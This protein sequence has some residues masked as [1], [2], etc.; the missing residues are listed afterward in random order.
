MS[1]YSS[2]KATIN[3]NVKTNGNQEITGSVM[4]SVLNAMVN[5]LGAGY[6]FMGVATPTNPGTA[7]TPDYKCFYIATTPGTYTNLGGLVVSDGEVALLKWDTSWTKEVTGV[8][9]AAKVNQI[10]KSVSALVDFV[11][12]GE[13]VEII[14]I[15]NY[16][17]YNGS[18]GGGGRWYISGRTSHIIIPANPGERYL[19]KSD[20]VSGLFGILTSDHSEPVANNS[21]ISYVSGQ[22]RRNATTYQDV[23]IPNGAAYLCLVMV[24]GGQND[25]KWG[26]VAKCGA[27][28]KSTQELVSLIN[29]LSQS[30]IDKVEY[31]TATH[32]L[33]IDNQNRVFNLYNGIS[34]KVKG[35]AAVAVQISNVPFGT[36]TRVSGWCCLV[37]NT[38]T[39]SI[40][41]KQYYNTEIT[42]TDVII[43]VFRALLDHESGSPDTFTIT[44]VYYTMLA[45]KLLNEYGVLIDR[46][47]GYSD[48][49]DI[50]GTQK[51]IES[52]PNFESGYIGANGNTG[53]SDSVVRSADYLR[54]SYNKIYC[55]GNLSLLQSI[56]PNFSSINFNVHCYN[57]K[58]QSLGRAMQGYQIVDNGAYYDLL[59]GTAFVRFT[60]ADIAPN[61]NLANY[62]S[63]INSN[64][65]NIFD[66]KDIHE[67]IF[68]TK[69]ELA[70][71]E[72]EM[73]IRTMLDYSGQKISL[74]QK[75]DYEHIFSLRDAGV[76]NQGAAIYGNYLFAFHTGNAEVDVYD[77]TTNTLVQ[78]ISV[79]D[80]P[81]GENHANNADFGVAFA[82]A[83]DL[84]PLLYVTT[85]LNDEIWVYRVSGTIGNLVMTKHQVISLNTSEIGIYPISSFAV[86]KE[87]NKIVFTGYKNANY[88]VSV[89]NPGVVGYFEIPDTSSD[90]QVASAD[91]HFKEVPWV[92]AFQGCFAVAG[93]IYSAFGN[94]H[95]SAG[96]CVYDYAN[97]I[98]LN[99][100]AISVADFGDYFEPEGLC[101][102]NGEMIMTSQHLKVYNFAF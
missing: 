52:I 39:G 69:E 45:Y 21:V 44:S 78:T 33:V 8:A 67:P 96:I 74:R 75:T 5:S 37:Y 88:D 102:Y 55:K 47:I 29:T 77:L 34:V 79:S 62:L 81:Q 20:S 12:G 90:I 9:A 99:K 1:E 57:E 35:G 28:Y 16:Q 6:Q 26:L 56:I 65:N 3:A 18:L 7:Q 24:D 92:Y 97:G 95:V 100:I 13:D 93:K 50:V 25:T 66:L 59:E 14:D 15:S 94:T 53:A 38:T 36:L 4:N 58:K 48:I 98:V 91:V 86:D 60:F 49:L 85:N 23:V 68:A 61:V 32:P 82:D 10:E 84:F 70:D 2:L 64:K 46:N 19:L 41:V 22:S 63:D 27:N 80:N 72:A 101:E 54:I 31:I 71:V 11:Q 73:G 42:D 40:S 30:S 83:S 43:A 17:V 89:N 87:N 51:N 76:Y